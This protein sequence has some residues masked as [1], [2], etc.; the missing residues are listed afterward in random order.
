MVVSKQTPI[1]LDYL[2]VG[3]CV[4]ILFL[5]PHKQEMCVRFFL[6]RLVLCVGAGWRLGNAT[7]HFFQLSIFIIFFKITVTFTISLL[8]D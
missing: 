3:I 2:E 1:Y 6:T 4:L 7:P 5:K 8:T